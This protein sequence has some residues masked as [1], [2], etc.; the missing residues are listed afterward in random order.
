MENS[1]LLTMLR[2]DKVED[3]KRMYALFGRVSN[4]HAL[5]REMMGNYVR[6][7]GKSLIMDEEKQVSPF[8]PFHP[9]FLE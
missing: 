6:E 3:L 7:T 4:G 9:L 8:F 5:M 1:G 2:D